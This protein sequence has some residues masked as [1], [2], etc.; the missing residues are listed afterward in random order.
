MRNYFLQ[1]QRQI[2]TNGWLFIGASLLFFTVH[3]GTDRIDWVMPGFIVKWQGA[4]WVREF[5]FVIGLMFV[6]FGNIKFVHLS[7]VSNL[8]KTWPGILN[9]LK[10]MGPVAFFSVILFLVFLI[11]IRP[12]G[13]EFALGS[14]GVAYGHYS[15]EVFNQPYGWTHRRVLMPFIAGLFGLTGERGYYYFFLILTLALV[16]VLFNEYW[17]K[18][19]EMKSLGVLSK[20]VIF[21]SFL[22]SSF[23]SF[24]FQFPGYVDVLFLLFGAILMFWVTSEVG[25][26]TLIVL[27]LCVHENALFL[28]APMLLYRKFKH[29]RSLGWCILILYG[30]FWFFS[31]KFS[32]R[33]LFLAQT[34]IGSKT[35]LQYFTEAPQLAIW[36]IFYAYKLFWVLL[37]IGLASTLSRKESYT[38]IAVLLMPLVTLPVAV[39]TSRL[40]GI[41]YLGIL[42]L[43]FKILGQDQIKLNRGVFIL[44]CIN[45]TIP[46]FYVGLN[47]GFIRFNGIYSHL[48]L[49]DLWWRIVAF[50]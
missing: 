23:F 14:Q 4:A 46:P 39:D 5:S 27:S 41:G 3:F 44:A 6:I 15:L 48:G 33:G 8:L 42:I 9:R 26:I 34:E 38:D 24:Q 25:I 22:T 31:A 19:R 21:F 18:T 30:L 2:A 1:L 32:L 16:I 43:L 17:Q 47:T 40:A 49:F 50:I 10:S 12:Y 36:G 7:D 45:L 29:V 37:L 20:G 13:G 28:L 35:A 11:L